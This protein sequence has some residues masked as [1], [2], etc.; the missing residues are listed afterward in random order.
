MS[1]PMTA[2]TT[3][4]A[5]RR[6]TETTHCALIGQTSCHELPAAPTVVPVSAEPAVPRAA[7]RLAAGRPGASARPHAAAAGMDLP[8]CGHRLDRRRRG[9]LP[10]AVAE[11]GQGLQPRL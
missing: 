4:L 6:R 10:V 7:L 3:H 8:G 9:G 11:Q 1:A 2:P 5:R